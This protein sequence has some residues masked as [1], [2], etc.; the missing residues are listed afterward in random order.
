LLER[1]NA[2]RLYARH[3]GR[4]LVEL[5]ARGS[6]PRARRAVRV[7]PSASSKPV[8]ATLQLVAALAFSV[9]YVHYVLV[10]LL[11]LGARALLP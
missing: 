1:S 2:A 3:G 6:V 5:D 8:V 9:A 11:A 7:Q 10:P 4:V